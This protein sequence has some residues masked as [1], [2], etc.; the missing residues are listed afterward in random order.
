MTDDFN[1]IIAEDNQNSVTVRAGLQPGLLTE[2]IPTPRH[3]PLRPG[4]LPIIL[5]EDRP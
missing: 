1:V 3:L 2:P 5:G 4:L